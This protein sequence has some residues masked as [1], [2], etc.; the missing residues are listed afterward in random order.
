LD[1]P[2]RLALIENTR[3]FLKIIQWIYR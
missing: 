3:N 1:D 2:L